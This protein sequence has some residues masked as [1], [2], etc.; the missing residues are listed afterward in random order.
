MED[1]KANEESKINEGEDQE[2]DKNIDDTNVKIML[3]TEQSDNENNIKKSDLAP[4][5]NVTQSFDEEGNPSIQQPHFEV[6]A[7]NLKD[8]L[9][10]P[11]FQKERL[12]QNN[13][14]GVS[15]GLAYTSMGGSVLFLEAIF[16]DWIQEE[17]S[18][19]KDSKSNQDRDQ[20]GDGEDK[21]TKKKKP[22]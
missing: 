6:T 13:P 11:R 2:S 18:E 3:E 19:E 20:G 7:D 17:E 5:A 21:E 9:G 1:I 12:Y 14:P 4:D 22:N 15:T 16:E 8:Y 10:A